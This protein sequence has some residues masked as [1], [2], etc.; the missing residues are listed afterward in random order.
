MRAYF[1]K[2]ER[3]GFSRWA[4]A[5]LNLAAQLW[6]EPGVTRFIC[7]AG[8]FTRQDIIDRLN[9]EMRND[10]LFRVQYWPIFALA[11]DDLIGC[12]GLRPFKSEALPFE[13]GVHLREQ[14]WGM[15]YAAEA[16]AAVI[17]YG[18]TVLK[19]NGLYAG[20]HPLNAASEKLL[21]KLGFRFVGKDYYEPTGLY[22]PSYALMNV[23]G[24]E[25]TNDP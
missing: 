5:D 24:R 12:C 19:A 14:Y 22:H 6:G 4:V 3:I 21:T 1:M 10:A 2:T 25:T 20:H 16:A 13:F 18:F 9:A 15:G 7:A 11:T 23:G 17:E 8:T